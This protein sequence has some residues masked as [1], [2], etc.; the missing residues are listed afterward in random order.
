VPLLSSHLA[1]FDRAVR[2]TQ[3]ARLRARRA[4]HDVVFDVVF[5]ETQD[6]SGAAALGA[7]RGVSG[8]GGELEV[9]HVVPMR[10]HL[11]ESRSERL[12]AVAQPLVAVRRAER[13]QLQEPLARAAGAVRRIGHRDDALTILLGRA[14][15]L[16]LILVR[17][18]ERQHGNVIR[19]G[20][21]RDE[22]VQAPLRAK[23]GRTW[24]KWR[25]EED[26][27]A[28]ANDPGRVAQACSPCLAG[29]E[30]AAVDV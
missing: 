16:F 24:Q 15:R 26:R 22:L 9:H 7:R 6:R 30:R 10:E 8:H 25:D 23:R 11:L 18:D 13:G 12:L 2:A 19:R 4:P 20:Q 21:T 28:L 14:D 3:R 1:P 29:G 5:V 27:E 17:I